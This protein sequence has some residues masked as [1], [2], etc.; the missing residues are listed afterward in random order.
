MAQA[1]PNCQLHR[2]GWQAARGTAPPCRRP[3]SWLPSHLRRLSARGRGVQGTPAMCHLLFLKANGDPRLQGLKRLQGRDS[4][5]G[6][7]WCGWPSLLPPQDQGQPSLSSH[8]SPPS[9]PGVRVEATLRA[10]AIGFSS[11]AP[12]RSSLTKRARP[13]GKQGACPQELCL[14]IMG[15]SY[16][17]AEGGSSRGHWVGTKL[18]PTG[19]RQAGWPGSQQTPRRILSLL[20]SPC[21]NQAQ[22]CPPLNLR[23]LLCT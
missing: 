15:S 14:G 20:S 11:G 21:L 8:Q 3:C 16:G 13:R 4:D 6:P 5:P 9:N 2:G 18:R 10:F 7:G 1:E 19:T 23:A 17:S 22:S 12:G